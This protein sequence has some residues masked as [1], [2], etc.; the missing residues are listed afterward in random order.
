MV[1]G[2]VAFDS[3]ETPKGSREMALGALLIF[4]QSLRLIFR[5]ST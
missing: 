2:S 4:S 5:L 1:V 3:I